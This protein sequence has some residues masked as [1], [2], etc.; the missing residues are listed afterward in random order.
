M[1]MGGGGGRATITEPNYAMYDSMFQQQKAKRRYCSSIRTV[2]ACP[3]I[4]DSEFYQPFFR[5]SLLI[6]YPF[7]SAI[8]LFDRI[9][10]T[11]R[12]NVGY[13]SQSGF[14]GG[15]RRLE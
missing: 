8:A 2:K 13:Q 10:D 3:R 11:N 14:V 5:A 9:A 1:C 15:N 7:L 4:L 6:L 12:Q